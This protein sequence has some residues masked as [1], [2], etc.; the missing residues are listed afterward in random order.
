MR[1]IAEHVQAILVGSGW[2]PSLFRSE[3]EILCRKRPFRFGTRVMLVDSNYDFFED[4]NRS[5]TLDECLSPFG[6]TTDISSLEDVIEGWINE[7]NLKLIKGKSIAVRW[8]RIEGGINGLN[9]QKLAKF[10]GK[11]LKNNGWKIDLESP[12]VELMIII[13][14]I[15]EH[16]FW[17]KRIISKH[18]RDGWVQRVATE[19][20]FFKPI[21]L[22]PRLARVALN[23]V[24]RNSET[25]ICD[26]MC[27]T[28][29]VL[30][31][32]ALLNQPMVGIDLDIEMVKGSKEN[33]EWLEQHN[34]DLKLQ[35]VYHGNAVNVNELLENKNIRIGG[36]VFD[37]PYGKN[38]WKSEKR[39]DLFLDVL[40]NIRKANGIS[41]GAGLVCFLPIKP[42][43]HGVNEP[44]NGEIDLGDYS[45]TQLKLE[46][47]KMGWEI[48]G[49]HAIPIHGSLARMLVYANAI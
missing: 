31:E 41:F 39:K 18:P 21:S 20:P 49:M 8:V 44:I 48:M 26:P 12:D 10:C 28:G 16:I 32:G 23:F 34:L 37:P 45:T 6:L 15:S 42:G 9:G 29:G 35:N 47:N 5:A 40:K 25:I 4:L 13:D 30:L 24:I 17:G 19:R 33:L 22:D 14:G 46:F 27:G 7:N 11:I 43:L 1:C 3:M 38:A 2:H 36:V